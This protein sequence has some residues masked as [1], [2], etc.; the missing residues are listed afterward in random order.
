MNPYDIITNQQGSTGALAAYL[1]FEVL[2]TCSNHPRLGVIDSHLAQ[3]G[4]FHIHIS[5][6]CAIGSSD[7]IRTTTRAYAKPKPSSGLTS[8]SSPNN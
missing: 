7:V 5:F 1:S 6:R 3:E 8:A 4:C 2:K